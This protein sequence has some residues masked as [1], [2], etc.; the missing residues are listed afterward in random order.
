MNSTVLN[1][2]QFVQ[3]HYQLIEN[4]WVF[5]YRN[6]LA[7][8][9]HSLSFFGGHLAPPNG[10]QSRLATVLAACLS[11]KVLKAVGES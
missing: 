1:L 7:Q 10:K 8:V 11:G 9:L 4:L 3:F 6:P 2:Q 5:F